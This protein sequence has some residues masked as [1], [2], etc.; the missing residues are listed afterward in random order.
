MNLSK[1]EKAFNCW[2]GRPR[3]DSQFRRCRS[4]RKSARDS[5][6]KKNAKVRRQILA[7]YGS[8]C[9]CCGETNP[10][11]LCLDHING[12]GAEDR[13]KQKG[14]GSRFYAILVKQKKRDDLQILCF[15]CNQGRERNKG[16]CPHL[17]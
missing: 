13:L 15:N 1:Q 3:E 10:L 12:D 6:N 9:N 11:F 16:I 2:C 4:C 14:R 8:V 17:V 7:I 5:Q